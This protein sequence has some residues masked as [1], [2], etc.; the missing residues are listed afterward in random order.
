MENQ[1]K[2]YDKMKQ[3]A[4]NAESNSFPGMEKVWARVEEKLDKKEDK[5]IIAL[6]KKIAVAASLLLFASLGYQFLRSDKEIIT[7][8]NPIVIENKDTIQNDSPLKIEKTKEEVA[9]STDVEAVKKSNKEP[10]S[11]ETILKNSIK[12]EQVASVFK[13]SLMKLKDLVALDEEKKQLVSKET[14]TV[15]I[16][17]EEVNKLT[18]EQ[19]ITGV[20]VD[21]ANFPL[22]G[23]T[24]LVRGTSNGT[25]TDFDGKFSI[26]V[27]K[28]E[29]L[30][31][32][33]VGMVT[34]TA[35]IDNS[36]N[37]SIAL[38][39]D[40]NTL[41]EV[42]VVGYGTQKKQFITS[43]V[44]SVSSN[45]IKK[46]RKRNTQKKA[47][48]WNSKSDKG[49]FQVKADALQS[50]SQ[51]LQGK[52]A[53]VYIN[54]AN[55]KYKG[56][57]TITLRGTNSI[58]SKQ[59]PLIILDERPISQKE[60]QVLSPNDIQDITV[61]KDAS[62]TSLYG[63][64]ASNG[65]IVITSKNGKVEKL[66]KRQLKK[67][68]KEIEEA[69]KQI[70]IQW[71]INDQTQDE[72]YEP[73][74]ENAFES[75]S[76]APLSTF[77][78]DV[79]NASYT[80]IRRFINNGQT[81]PK[82]AV[83]VEEMV[84]FFQY[85]YA[86]PNHEHP[87]SI[88]TDYSDCAW[89]SNHK[90]LKVGLQG[91]NI[92]TENLP[93]SNLVFLI[94][95]SGSMNDQ[96]KLPLLKQSMK[97]LVEQLRKKDKVSIVVYAGAAGL[98]LPPTSGDDK[99]TIIDAL[100]KLQAGGSTAGG[101]GIELAYKIAQEN[102]IKSGNNRVILATDGDFNVGASSDKDMQTLIEDKRKSGV[103]LTCLGYGMGN[104]KDSKMETIA[105]KGNGNYAYI[106]NIQEANRFLG[107]EFKGSMFAIAKDVKIQIEF[108][109]Q[110]VQAYRLIGYENRK[111]R[112]E[113]FV[114][115]AIDAGELGSGHTV[116]ALYEIIP[117]NVK[118]D[119]FKEPID[120]KY[121][122]TES[123]ST[124]FGNE[125]A[126][127]KFRYKKPDGEKSI[128][129]VHVIENKSIPIENSSDDF[130]FSSA[131]AWFGLKLRDSKLVQN[132]DSEAIKTLARKGLS[133]DEDGYKSEFI[134]LV[135]T[136]K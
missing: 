71:P 64:R 59:E 114:N 118:S 136:V 8:E 132:K 108:N 103:F 47:L 27:K 96:N 22:P 74:E 113:D 42:V 3:A 120:L 105:N 99:K 10:I 115:D 98:V 110:H 36:T 85:N 73:F 121:S 130:K 32:S 29:I 48:V 7:N 62:A 104:Y 46:D 19:T 124:V 107:K 66:S 81:V 31:F 129:M 88:H 18:G 4:H 134:R 82:D 23:V 86:E 91:K 1:D 102:F 95:V 41:S 87:F 11:N 77:S 51:S 61:L 57:N 38:A 78:I 2:L 53:G 63:N 94:D 128:E 43:S 106:D 92:P 89:N 122:K 60:M 69:Q 83:R 70:P 26:R 15:K 44:T 109:P 58:N 20:V 68:L 84:N 75:P 116:T 97:I 54:D 126:T 100:E 119:F 55:Q 9:V 39:D 25:Q 112:D 17:S 76:T 16:S 80:N 6:W 35:K 5:K 49:E 125:L 37:L 131:V 14:P 117:T 52:V 72:S 34:Q 101:A 30:E 90:V 127:I 28:G 33:Y 93:S 111:L 45:E 40:G 13:D 133:N 123:S 50:N 135:E 79:D 21:N 56:N 12:K 24:V 67:R 65:V